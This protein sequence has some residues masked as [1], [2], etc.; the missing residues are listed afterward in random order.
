MVTR[1]S[2]EMKRNAK[3]LC[4][5]VPYLRALAQPQL[6]LRLTN[7][8]E[9]LRR[10]WTRKGRSDPEQRRIDIVLRGADRARG[11]SLFEGRLQRIELP[12][13]LTRLQD[14]RGGRRKHKDSLRRV[15]AKYC[16]LRLAQEL[17]ALRRLHECRI[18]ARR[19]RHVAKLAGGCGNVVAQLTEQLQVP[20]GG[21]ELGGEC[22]VEALQLRLLLRLRLRLQL[23]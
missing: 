8:P 22:E 12:Q 21:I 23:Q 4:I 11:Q 13:L 5:R 18:S 10:V 1:S 14:G 9:K 6:S 15:T 17:A 3:S 16:R 2:I 19:A 7:Q 20:H